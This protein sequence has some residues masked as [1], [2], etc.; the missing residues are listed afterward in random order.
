VRSPNQ[1]IP[2]TRRSLGALALLIGLAA[3]GAEPL[4]PAAGVDPF[5]ALE[6]TAADL[7]RAS[8]P[9]SLSCSSDADCGG[10]ACVA[11]QCVACQRHADCG[12]DVCDTSLWGPAGYG[13][14]L[15]EPRVIYVDAA[16]CASAGG[17]PPESLGTGT[18]SDPLCTIHEAVARASSA[19]PIVRVRP[20]WYYPFAVENKTIAFYGPAGEGGHAEVTE[21]DVGG[22]RV[23]EAA[24]AIF[25][26]FVLGRHSTTGLR[27]EGGKAR[28][29]VQI[30][31]SEV[32][33]DV[34]VALR[35]GDGCSIKVER[36]RLSGLYGAVAIDGA[37]YLF[38]NSIIDGVGE[39]AAVR[40]G[41]GS[42]RFQFSTIT[43]NVEASLGVE[44]A[45]DCGAGPVRITDS[46]VTGNALGPSGSQF[47]GNC[48]LAR[49]VVGSA[50]S[51][52]GQPGAIA[53]DPSFGAGFTLPRAAA[54][55]DCCIDRAATNF[56]VLRDFAGNARPHG[57]RWDIGALETLP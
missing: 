52:G 7:E 4:D 3:C 39:R 53:K 45:F 2:L 47:R 40:V 49:V 25:D 29:Q 35:A 55:L 11:N 32:L 57:R 5:T 36:S 19:Q 33:S 15:P 10:A 20:G 17:Y 21:E 9:L 28:A 48:Q 30:R 43:G 24:A 41:S 44:G 1:V 23:G 26:G 46:I 14:C 56:S 12:S 8:R 38:T 54:N 37:H 22:V 42:G 50:D 27:C 51:L 13:V 6:P 31:R 18:K 34:G 16:S